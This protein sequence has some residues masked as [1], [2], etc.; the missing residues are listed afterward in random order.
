MI[1][2]TK[3]AHSFFAYLVVHGVKYQVVLFLYS[4]SGKPIP[5]TIYF[6]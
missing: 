3:C 6:K 1:Y 2:L 5:S 4:Y